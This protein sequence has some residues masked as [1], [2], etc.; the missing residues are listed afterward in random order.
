ME[1]LRTADEI[2]DVNTRYH[3]VAAASYDAKWGIDFGDVGQSQVLGKIRKLLG[4]ELRTGYARGLE[5]GAGTG[6][7]SLNLLQAGVLEEAT[8]TDISPGMVTTLGANARRLGLQ[9]R[10]ARADAESLPFADASF[11]FAFGHA[12]LHH[13]PDLP[14]AFAEL[15]RVLRPGGRILFAG[16][17]SRMG[18]R[19]ARVPKRAARLLAPAW[20][21]ALRVSPASAP[22]ETDSKAAQDHALEDRVDIHAF[23]PGDLSELARRAGFEARHVRGEELLANWFGWL[24]RGLESTAQFSEIPRMWIN[25]AYHGYLLLQRVDE[26]LLEPYLPPAIFYNLLLTARKPG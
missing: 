18:D 14:R 3:D 8:C 20:R 11:D 5:I 12:V 10:T 21:A 4:D 22:A 13:L 15:Y 24:N 6:Y 26:R 7:F 23:A 16:E 25:Y 1:A 17:P 19:L 9:V 2:R